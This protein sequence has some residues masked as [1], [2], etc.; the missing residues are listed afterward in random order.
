MGC[1]KSPDHKKQL[2]YEIQIIFYFETFSFCQKKDLIV[3]T[4]KSFSTFYINEGEVKIVQIGR[5][6]LKLCLRL[7]EGVLLYVER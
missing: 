1:K 6:E 4:I 7:P 2:L 3:D 5:T